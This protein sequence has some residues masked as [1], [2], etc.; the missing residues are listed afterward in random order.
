MVVPHIVGQLQFSLVR[1]PQSGF[2]L[3]AE[4]KILDLG[5]VSPIAGLVPI[6]D[7]IPSTL[8]N[9]KRQLPDNF[10]ESSSKKA[11]VIGDM[12]VKQLIEN[13]HRLKPT[14]T[15]KGLVIVL[16]PGKK[17]P[18]PSIEKGKYTLSELKKMKYDLEQENKQLQKNCNLIIQYLK[19]NGMKYFK[20]ENLTNN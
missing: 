1:V 18:S 2:D 19:E 8:Q 4:P 15:S 3:M 9:R 16:T 6:P 13:V 5:M 7:K 10:S 20:C 17:T 11:K 12:T 14:V